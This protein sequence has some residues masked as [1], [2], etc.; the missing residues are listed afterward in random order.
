MFK[1]LLAQILAFSANLTGFNAYFL[2]L[3]ILTI[4]GL[5][6]PIPEDITLILGGM[7]AGVG[8][9]SLL[10]AMI[11]GFIGVLIG[12]TFLFFLGRKFGYRV[13]KFKLVKKMLSEERIQKARSRIHKNSKFICFTA[14]FFPGLRA[15]IYLVAGAMKVSPATFLI[16]DGFAA[17]VSVPVWVY[18]GYYV[19]K[20]VS[21]DDL[22]ESQYIENIEQ[23]KSL[24]LFGILIFVVSYVIYKLY[25]KKKKRR[26]LS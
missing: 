2:I 20:R 17:L 12:D 26:E 25:I 15:P 5:G 22:F 8:N 23:V 11:A 7:L 13:F 4:C 6:V 18:L 24:F 10:G 3:L 1:E 19:G 9:I 14:R 21:I 16:L